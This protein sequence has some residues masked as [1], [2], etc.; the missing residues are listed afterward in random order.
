MLSRNMASRAYA[1]ASLNRSPRQQDADVFRLVIARL[2][3]ARQAAPIAR[4]RALADNRRLWTA[5]TD[6]LRDPTNPLPQETRAGIISVGLS[7]QREMDQADPSFDFLIS[8]N[9]NIADGLS[10]NP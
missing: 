4:V 2:Q 10:G 1:A 6:L 3:A 8:V 9:R 7:V 5:V